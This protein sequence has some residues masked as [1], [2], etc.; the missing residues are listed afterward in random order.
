MGFTP[1][2]VVII[3]IFNVTRNLLFSNFIFNTHQMDILCKAKT[4]YKARK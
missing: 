1:T 3:S 2:K 4:C